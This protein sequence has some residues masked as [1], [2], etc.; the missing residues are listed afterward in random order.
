[1]FLHFYGRL[2]TEHTHRI[3]YFIVRQPPNYGRK[4]N[5]PM[6]GFHGLDM[7]DLGMCLHFEL[8]LGWARTLLGCFWAQVAAYVLTTIALWPSLQISLCEFSVS[9]SQ[10]LTDA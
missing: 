3:L 10:A 1:M 4:E 6:G 9:F 5:R 2:P 7:A 8:V